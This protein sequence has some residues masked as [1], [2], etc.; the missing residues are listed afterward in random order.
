MT[1]RPA[2]FVDRDGTIIA[3]RA[4][5]ADPAGVELVPGA[6]EAL[7][8]LRDAGF[9][10]V[11]VT[12]QSGIARGLYGEADYHAV[13][14]RL[15]EVLAAGGVRVDRTEFCMH[16]PDVTGPCTCRKPGTGMHLRAAADLGLDPARSYFVGDKATDVLPALALG[17]QGILVRTGY[18]REEESVIPE[19]TWVATDLL[20][21]ARLILH[22]DGR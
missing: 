4:Y 10:L 22:D 14:A 17:G 6:L 8:S 15:A 12:N 13:A 9:A 5:L 20:E 7:V 16:H 18:G 2:V 11:T 1:L 21:A 3:E 19:G